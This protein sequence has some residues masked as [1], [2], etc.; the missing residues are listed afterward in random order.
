MTN[1]PIST[2]R[3][4]LAQGAM[5][6]TP[7]ALTWLLNRDVADAAPFKPN[8]EQPV[9]DL[10]PKTPHKPPQAKAMISLF[11]QGGPSQIDLLDP[12]PILNK[13]DGQK[14]P[15]TIKYDNA[16]QASSKVLGS[17]WRFEP[18]GECGTEISELLPHISTIA[19]DICV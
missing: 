15:G 8:L 10:V 6:L 4:F 7:L 16:A 18:R 14:F 13:L 12:K 1:S 17:P 2:R 19:D 3:H 9:F 11:M 5:S